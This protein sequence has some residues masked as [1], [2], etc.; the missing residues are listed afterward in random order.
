MTLL[1]KEH[2]AVQNP[3]ASYAQAA[4][5]L[6]PNVWAREVPLLFRLVHHSTLEEPLGIGPSLAANSAIWSQVLMHVRNLSI[7]GI[8][9]DDNLAVRAVWLSGFCW[10]GM[11]VIP[12][13]LTEFSSLRPFPEATLVEH[14]A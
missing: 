9:V 5:M 2:F 8:H 12:Q 7:V 4:R 13:L 14:T 1:S 10:I 3:F 11:P 6:A